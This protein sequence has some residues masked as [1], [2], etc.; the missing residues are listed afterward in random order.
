MV[1][2]KSVTM[3]QDL[4]DAVAVLLLEAAHTLRREER[5]DLCRILENDILNPIGAA[6]SP[7]VQAKIED[8]TDRPAWRRS[9]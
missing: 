6:V 4:W 7:P 2:Q 9:A 8:I 1:A 3:P 5:E